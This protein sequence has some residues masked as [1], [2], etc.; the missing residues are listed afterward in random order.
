MARALRGELQ[1][2]CMQ[3]ERHARSRAMTMLP[4]FCIHMHDHHTGKRSWHSQR[5]RR[6]DRMPHVL[7]NH[8]LAATCCALRLGVQNLARCL[9]PAFMH[10]KNPSWQ[11]PTSCQ[12][13]CSTVCNGHARHLLTSVCMRW[14]PSRKLLLLLPISAPSRPGDTTQGGISV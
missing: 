10:K 8:A 11:R 6:N 13:I 3:H 5:Y 7:C 14:P 4:L 2:I 1:S 12:Q 9:R